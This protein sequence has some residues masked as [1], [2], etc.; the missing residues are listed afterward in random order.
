MPIKIQCPGCQQTLKVKDTLAGKTIRCPSCQSHCKV[1]AAD[2]PAPLQMTPETVATPKPESAE[3]QI[4]RLQILAALGQGGF[5]TV[6]RAWDPI[7]N[8]EVAL[9]VPRGVGKAGER[10]ILE[11][12]AAAPLHHPNIVAVYEAGADGDDLFIATEY[13]E[14]QT[15]VDP[16][17]GK[18]VD[19]SLAAE[20]VKSLAEALE[21]AHGEGVIHRDVKPHNIMIGQAD[22]AQLMDFGLAVSRGDE[23]GSSPTGDSTIAGTPAYMSPEQARGDSQQTGPASDQYSLGA[24]LY[25]LLTGKPPFRGGARDRDRDC[26]ECQT[27]CS[28][29]GGRIGPSRS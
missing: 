18:E 14:G 2:P 13:V 6:Y 3:S 22:R 19:S 17:S 11:A 16:I 24:V 10:L 9:K 4:G 23:A 27:N 21:Y 26:G 15:L 29:N 12:R 28:A 20:W 7:L 5:G 1:P 25:E 8:R